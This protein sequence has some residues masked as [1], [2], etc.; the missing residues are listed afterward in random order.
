MIYNK[1]LAQKESKC[2]DILGH[3]LLWTMHKIFSQKMRI[4][5]LFL[6][7]RTN[8]RPISVHC[9]RDQVWLCQ[10]GQKAWGL[11][12]NVVHLMLTLMLWLG[13]QGGQ[14]KTCSTG[15]PG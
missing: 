3:V 7:E 10:Q 11:L 9:R 2:I 6:F 12:E 1:N 4:S 15:K 13:N 14:E 5:L 8:C